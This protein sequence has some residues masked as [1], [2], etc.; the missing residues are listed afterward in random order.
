[1]KLANSNQIR[2]ALISELFE[3]FSNKSEDCGMIASNSFN[4]P[5]VAE[6]GE[7]G[8]V[9]IVVKVPKDAGDDG[10]AKREEYS[11]KCEE[12]AQKAK[13]Q[14]EAKAKKIAK[15]KKAREAKAKA[16]EKEE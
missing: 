2:T 9:E 14:A 10:Y 4:F 5:V 15:D 7:E 1:M 3:Y 6:D 12:R 11:M 16:K 8:M 13:A